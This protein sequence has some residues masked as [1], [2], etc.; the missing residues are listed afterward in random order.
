MKQ[1]WGFARGPP[2]EVME[3]YFMSLGAAATSCAA[4]RFSDKEKAWIEGYSRHMGTPNVKV[5]LESVASVEEVVAM[6][7]KVNP[8]AQPLRPMIFDAIRAAS[9]DGYADQEK[10]TTRKIA[11]AVDI[12]TATVELI[13]AQVV[14][15]AELREK[16]WKLLFPEGS[17]F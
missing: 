6:L 16:R 3:T 7:S 8:A 1:E 10:E 11:A 5:S 14:A 9:V 17:P 13:E 2:K 15:E 4:D 12:D